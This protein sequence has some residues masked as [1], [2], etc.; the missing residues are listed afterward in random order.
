MRHNDHGMALW[1][2]LVKKDT[3]PTR[4]ARP[5]ISFTLHRIRI[6]VAVENS[7]KSSRSP[8][9]PS[10]ASFYYSRILVMV[11]FTRPA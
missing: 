8:T 10:F 9:T 3:T 11:I 7:S 5:E 6:D 2:D 1:I 4:A